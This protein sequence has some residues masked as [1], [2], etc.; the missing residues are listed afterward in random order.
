MAKCHEKA[1]KSSCPASKLRQ[2]YEKCVR[3]S[4]KCGERSTDVEGTRPASKMPYKIKKCQKKENSAWAN[5]RITDFKI[6]R[7]GLKFQ[8][9]YEKVIA[10][11]R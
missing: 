6:V 3:K 5:E 7:V 8:Q 4:G 1:S 2:N 9:N 11:K 10:E